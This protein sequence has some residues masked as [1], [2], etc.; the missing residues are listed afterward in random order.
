MKEV[1][2][3]YT[4]TLTK[5]ADSDKENPHTKYMCRR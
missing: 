2:K 5:R 3:G 4:E 1:E